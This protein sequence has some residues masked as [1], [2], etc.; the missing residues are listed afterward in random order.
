MLVP[1]WDANHYYLVVVDFRGAGPPSV[2]QLDSGE[3][4]EPSQA[5][6]HVAA[7]TALAIG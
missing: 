1:I 7:S 2:W 3:P 6:L 4:I 5:T